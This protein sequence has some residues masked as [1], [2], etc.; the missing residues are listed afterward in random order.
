MDWS[1]IHWMQFDPPPEGLSSLLENFLPSFRNSLLPVTFD[2]LRFS[3]LLDSVDVMLVSCG[4]DT[5]QKILAFTHSLPTLCI[6]SKPG[7][8]L[9]QQTLISQGLRLHRMRHRMLGG[10]TNGNLTLGFRGLS[11]ASFR[12]SSSLYQACY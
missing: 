1:S 3:A 11:F 10:V 6:P 7:K 4:D 8:G 9:R 12:P 5:M 2:A